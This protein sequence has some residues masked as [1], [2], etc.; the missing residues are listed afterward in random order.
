VHHSNRGSQYAA[1]LYR[2]LLKARGIECSMSRK[3]D[4]WDN[5]VAESFFATLKVELV[6]ETLFLTRAQARQEIFEY[7]EVFYN[8]VRRHS[9]IGYV[10]PVDYEGGNASDTK[11]A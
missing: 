4:C 11:A 1:K 10:S 6:Y 7:I 3:G 8:R 2:R 5:A 9:Y